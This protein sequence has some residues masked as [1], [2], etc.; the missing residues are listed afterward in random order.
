MQHCHIAQW[1]KW[2]KAF[3][4]GRDAI[5]D[6]LYTGRTHVENNT[7]QLLASLLDADHQLTVC[8]LAVEVKSMSQNCA[9]HSARHF[10]LPQTCS[11]LD[12]PWNFRGSTMAPLC[13][14]TGLVGPVPKGRWLLFWANRHYGPN[15]GSL[16]RPRLEMPIKWMEASWFSSSKE[17]VPYRMCCEVDVHCEVWQWCGNIAP[18][19]TFM[20]D[21]K[22]CILLQVPT[23]PPLSS[24]QEKTTT[25]GGT[26]PQPFLIKCKESHRCRSHG[27]LGPLE[28][29]D[30]GTSTILTRYVSM[31]LRSLRLR[32]TSTSKDPVQRK[33]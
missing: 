14:M 33:R 10:R 26:K 12:T 21:H 11:G 18:C 13:S 6:N 9:S 5:K 16:I 32:E 20:A 2:V 24:A 25:L 8:E 1:H 30:S 15:L 7:I 31:R 22:R 17:S 3:W 28:M 4:E 27:T 29:R 23:A 19:C